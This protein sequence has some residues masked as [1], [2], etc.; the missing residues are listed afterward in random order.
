MLQQNI[1]NRLVSVSTLDKLIQFE[2]MEG[3]RAYTA[4][5]FLTDLRKGI[6]K[7]LYTKQ[8]IDIYRRNLQKMHVEK[9]ISLVKPPATTTT[10]PAQQQTRLSNTNDAIS[11]LKGQV[12]SLA[13]EIRNTIPQTKD[14]PTRLH[15]QDVLERLNNSLKQD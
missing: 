12:R 11:V 9:L 15:L 2:A 13:V 14:V 3:A 6:W 7:E 8:P 5:E 1:L 4:T 10:M